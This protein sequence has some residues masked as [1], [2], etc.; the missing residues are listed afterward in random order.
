MATMP[1]RNGIK[2]MSERG[3]LS[4][5]CFYFILK[6]PY[7]EKRIFGLWYIYF[8]TIIGYGCNGFHR[9]ISLK[10]KYLATMIGKVNSDYI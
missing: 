2:L 4:I 10:N 3:L 7:V 5:L 1:Q 8:P 6:S 9:S